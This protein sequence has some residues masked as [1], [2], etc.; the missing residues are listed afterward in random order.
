M[1][2][3]WTASIAISFVLGLG[4]LGCNEE[5]AMEKA[6]RQLDEQVESAGDAVDDTLASAKEALEDEDEDEDE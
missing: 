2:R 6:G 4:T 1:K 3:L 5:G